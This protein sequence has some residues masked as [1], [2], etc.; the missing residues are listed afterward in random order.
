MIPKDTTSAQK[1]FG[2]NGYDMILS[3]LL[4]LLDTQFREVNG[5][6]QEE[7]T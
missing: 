4:Y 5:P 6:T 2:G 3:R 1:S 7:S